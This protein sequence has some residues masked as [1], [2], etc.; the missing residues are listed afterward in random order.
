MSEGK[1]TIKKS[2]LW[3]YATFVLVIIVVIGAIFIFK[4]NGSSTGTT[5]SSE[6]VNLKPFMSNSLL[7]PSLGPNNATNV[8]IEF[9]DFQCIWCALTSGLPSWATPN[10]TNSTAQQMI[11]QSGDMVGAIGKVEDMARQNKLRFI[12]V[13]VSFFGQESTWAA[14]A[15]Y[16]AA[17]Q[18]KFWE[19]HD[20]IYKAAGNGPSEN[21]GKYTKA[22]LTVIAENIPGLDIQKFSNCLNSNQTLTELQ[23]SMAQVQ[24]FGQVKGTPTVFVNGKSINPMWSTI[25]AALQ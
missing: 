6:V 1:I 8:V 12:Y 18:G 24:S 7:Y 25:Q 2:D 23:S 10:T 9:S 14:E 13:P 4:S 19:M 3:K 5:N 16:C 17:N 21:N 15:A 11:S 20:A 22:N